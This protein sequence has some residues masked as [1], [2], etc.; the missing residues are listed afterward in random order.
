MSIITD[1]IDSK[2]SAHVAT[3]KA[4]DSEFVAL[5]DKAVSNLY[6]EGDGFSDVEQYKASLASIKSDDQKT[7]E[8]KS[9]KWRKIR[10]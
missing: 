4:L 6:S 9:N 3:D 5:V 1:F 7:V 2:I 10:N 8:K